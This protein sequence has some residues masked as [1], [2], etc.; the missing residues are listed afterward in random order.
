MSNCVQFG[1]VLTFSH[2]L[3]H[4]DKTQALKPIE[5]AAE[6]FGAWQEGDREKTLDE[7]A[8]AIQAIANL[9]QA[10]GQYDMTPYMVRCRERNEARGRIYGV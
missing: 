1:P 10:L 3:I 8:D 2:D 5:E 6:I 7:C 9:C 4:D